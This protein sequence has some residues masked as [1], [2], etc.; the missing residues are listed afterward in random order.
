M[1]FAFMV[2]AKIATKPNTTVV[3][4]TTNAL[5]VVTTTCGREQHHSGA[6]SREGSTALAAN[7]RGLVS[8]YGEAP[9]A[10]SL[11]IRED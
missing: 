9:I 4:A 7:A 6:P 3:A 8:I 5:V 10:V 2:V 1:I 11:A